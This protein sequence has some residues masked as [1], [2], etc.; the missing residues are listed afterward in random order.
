MC[1][2]LIGH[3]GALHR[4]VNVGVHQPRPGYSWRSGEVPTATHALDEHDQPDGEQDGGVGRGSED[5]GP[6]GSSRVP[7]SVAGRLASTAAV[8][9]THLRAHET[10]HDLVCRLLLE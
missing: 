8:S 9:Y 6:P 7:S 5:L 4:G 2:V 3:E 10:R 1:G